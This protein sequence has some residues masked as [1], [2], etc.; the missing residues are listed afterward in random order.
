MKKYSI[1]QLNFENLRRNF[2]YKIGLLDVPIERIAKQDT[3]DTFR[4]EFIMR[5]LTGLSSILPI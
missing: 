5:P 3:A 4:P 1:E 2:V